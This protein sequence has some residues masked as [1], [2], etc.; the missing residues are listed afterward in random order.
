MV[1][2]NINHFSSRGICVDSLNLITILTL[3][4]Y[5]KLKKIK[6]DMSGFEQLEERLAEL[7]QIQTE[8]QGFFEITPEL[9]VILEP[10]G[11]FQI[12][13]PNWEQAL[14]WSKAVLKS[15]NW[16]EF[17]HPDDVD[18]S[19]S[20]LLSVLSK[21]DASQVVTLENRFRAKDGSYHW[22]SWRIKQC[23][24]GNLSALVRDLSGKKSVH[25][26]LQGTGQHFP[27][28]FQDAVI[29]MFQ[30]SPDGRYINFNPAM[31]RIYGYSSPS[32]MSAQFREPQ[33]VY[34]DPN[35]RDEFLEL[36]RKHLTIKEF[37]SQIYR[38]DGSVIWVSQTARAVHDSGGVFSGFEGILIDIT[39]RRRAEAERAQLLACEQAARL[40]AEQAEQRFRD[41]VNGLTDAIVWECDPQT[42]KFTFISQSA[43]R[44]LG[45]S[46]E[47]WQSKPSFWVNILHPDDRDWVTNFCQ[48]QVKQGRDHEF[49]YRCLTADG[50]TIWLRDRVSL[51][52]DCLGRVQCMRGLMVNITERKQ[53][54][55][56]RIHLLEQEQAD[57]RAKDEFLATVSHELRTPLTNIRMA[58]QMLKVVTQPQQRENYLRILEAE[59]TREIYLIN[60]LLDLQKF[61]DRATLLNKVPLQLQ[62]W[63]PVIIKP[64]VER[65][66]ARSQILK[67]VVP[68]DFP[69]LVSDLASLE[70]IV[71]ELLNNACKYTPPGGEITIRINSLAS[72][73]KS[74]GKDAVEII[75]SNSG[76]SIPTNELNRVFEKFYRIPSDAPWT[77]SGTGLGLAL[78]AKLVERLEGEIR[79]ES[80]M[81]LVSFIV[82]LPAQ[83]ELI[84]LD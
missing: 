47:Q 4:Q 52:L 35:R 54:E 48:E 16:T 18:F 23:S 67:L 69:V 1:L 11:S 6:K 34:V 9:L 63:F 22:L 24:G 50:H 13:S 37:E 82:T 26:P 28:L 57:N 19:D 44:I 17:L 55:I 29:G 7:T 78:V 61:Q 51:V 59:C 76:T 60:D 77:Q 58:I 56:E 8:L 39:R 41:L 70:R 84:V 80:Q 21:T 38:Q 14:G 49:E 43:E 12:L 30:A 66:I 40:K 79:A 65:A 45:Y 27:S 81:N 31:A 42:L 71:T 53:V 33:Q 64:F 15:H 20:C 2:K 72:T 73:F 10:D 36:I 74:S 5:I 62:Y 32:E 25:V 46:V 83:P 75:V 68:P 3:V